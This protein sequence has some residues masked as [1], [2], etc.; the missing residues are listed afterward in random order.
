MEFALHVG[1]PGENIDTEIIAGFWQKPTMSQD[2]A[3]VRFGTACVAGCMSWTVVHPLNTISVQRNLDTMVNP[4]TKTQGLLSF[5]TSIL[6]RDGLKGLYAGL[7]A[8]Y[9]RQV[10]YT[11]CQVGMFETLRDQVTKY[12]ELDLVTRL[13]VGCTS[14]AIAAVVSCPAEV[15]L[16]R[17]TNDRTLPVA[18]RR[19]YVNVLDAGVRI[20]REEGVLRLFSGCAPFVVRAILV[21]AFQIGTYDHVRAYLASLGVEGRLNLTSLASFAAAFTYSVVT[22]PLETAK[23]RLAFQRVDPS[24]GTVYKGTLDAMKGAIRSGGGIGGLWAGFTPYYIRCSVF[25][26]GMFVSLEALR[27]MINAARL[28]VN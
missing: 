11:T 19:G 6:R 21:G 27:E 5:V 28:R 4:G 23:N 15:A 1:L 26:V 16:V 24:T 13:L 9:T 3:F 12:R 25:S 8:G 2:S 18:Q 22:M 14:G 17:M 20:V 7:S 10:Y